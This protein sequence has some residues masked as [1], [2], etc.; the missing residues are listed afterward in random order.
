[1]PDIKYS[2][3]PIST[4][5]RLVW[6]DGARV[7][8]IVT[9]ALEC[10]DLVQKPGTY[11]GGPTIMPVPLPPGV[12]DWPNFMWREYGQRVGMWRIFDLLDKHGLKA[13]VPINTQ[14]GTHY[15]EVLKAARERNWEFVAHSRLQSDLLSGFAQDR[16]KE[17]AFLDT[18]VTEYKE[19]FGRA[20]RG[21]ISPSF[22]QS[23]NTLALLAERGFRWFCDF[24]N[25]D[26]PYRI[27]VE[28][29]S[30]LCIPQDMEFPDSSLMLRRNFTSAEYAATLEESF[31][32]LHEEGQRQARLMNLI[33]HPHV[34]GRADKIRSVDHVVKFMKKMGGVWFPMRE[35]IADWYD[36]QALATKA[37]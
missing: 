21:W 27:E 19:V 18:V 29:K 12:P 31:T 26:Q 10:W 17:A 28:G 13:S 37:A 2:K 7:A 36:S 33:I 9:V 3:E 25:D 1:M 5:R 4:R 15:P 14:F 6:P 34:L 30:I 23:G 16:T 20:P 11:S 8:V 22:S 35:D 24:G 32:V